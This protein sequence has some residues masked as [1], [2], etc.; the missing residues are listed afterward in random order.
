MDKMAELSKLNQRLF[1]LKKSFEEQLKLAK[2]IQ[3]IS[4]IVEFPHIKGFEFSTRHIASPVSGGDYLDVFEAKNS[5]G[6][7]LSAASNHK[8]AASLLRKILNLD[9]K[10]EAE[11]EILK[12]I[13]EGIRR[14]MGSTDSLS[15]LLILIDKKATKLNYLN[16][17]DNIGW[18][19]T[20]NN[21]IRLQRLAS[22]LDK[23]NF[24]FPKDVE[25]EILL[26]SRVILSSYGLILSSNNKGVPFGLSEM[27]KL[28]NMGKNKSPHE[29]KHEILFALDKHTNG[30]FERDATLMICDVKEDVRQYKLKLLSGGLS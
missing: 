1:D 10:A 22:R 4:S 15:L 20:D 28:I 9:T 14:E 25:E 29:L 7:L 17:G 2:E 5:V 27:E 11:V 30:K 19:Q 13:C 21:L 23:A 8:I 16:I 18:I 6:L 3:K 24:S 12:K 26:G